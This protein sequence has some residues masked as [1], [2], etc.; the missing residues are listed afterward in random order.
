MFLNTTCNDQQHCHPK[1]FYSFGLIFLK[2]NL[3]QKSWFLRHH[4]FVSSRALKRDKWTKGAKKHKVS[5]DLT[6]VPKIS[7]GTS[8]MSLLSDSA[9]VLPLKSHTSYSKVQQCDTRCQH[10][11]GQDIQFSQQEHIHYGNRDHLN[12]CTFIRKS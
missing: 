8:V 12:K 3:M 9:H 7:I 2:I 4:I 10:P 1:I 5:L 6:G 11:G